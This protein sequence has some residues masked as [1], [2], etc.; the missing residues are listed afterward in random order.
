M[1]QQIPE[2]LDRLP[3]SRFH[4]KLLWICGFGTLFDAMDIGIVGS[5]MA[6]LM[7]AWQLQPTELG[8][9]GSISF[10][11]MFL[12]AIFAGPLADRY[13]RKV[14]FSVTLGCFGIF[15]LLNAFAWNYESMLLFRF[16]TGLG[17]GAE[18]PIVAAYFSELVP[19]RARGRMLT[20]YESFFPWGL[21]LAS[22][23]GFLLVPTLGWQ[24]VFVV[25][26]VPAL[27][28]F[29]I[30][31]N[32]P[33]SPRWLV[34]RNREQEAEKIVR[35]IEA[36]SSREHGTLPP[37]KQTQQAK[38]IM[39][40]KLNIFEIWNSVYWKR[41]LFL[42]IGW[43]GI[44]YANYAMIL[45]LPSFWIQS[46]VTLTA[47][48]FYNILVSFAAVPGFWMVAL[49]ID[50]IGRKPTLILSLILGI[51]GAVGFSLSGSFG[52]Q[53][54]S[55]LLLSLGNGGAMAC[56]Y[57][58]S[59]ELYPT[60]MRATAVSFASSL[61]RIGGIVAP[62]VTGMI[63]ASA[64]NPA[65]IFLVIAAVIVVTLFVTLIFARETM[66]QNL[67]NLS[68]TNEFSSRETQSATI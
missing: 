15:S 57:T 12:G 38:P 65:V 64:G 60:R 35:D 63:L 41:T 11:G 26:A 39:K 8:L 51:L 24:S 46:G 53:L 52:L 29:V 42:W 32:L 1:I 58:Y 56:L 67:E 19:A 27:L 30:R 25:G 66:N 43:F 21:M 18:V 36:E 7:A 9:I 6:S 10:L 40:E 31:R 47:T 2:R 22:V 5:V 13:G 61:G 34:S 48:L 17:L 55:G 23:I 33:E 28:I 50:R 59:P 49:L 16:L 44:F 68:E 45:W 62:L 14:I 54:A 37:I 3:E 20:M 4:R